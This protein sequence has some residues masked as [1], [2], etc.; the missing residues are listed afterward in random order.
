VLPNSP[1]F[2]FDIDQALRNQRIAAHAKPTL[3]VSAGLSA[4][5]TAIALEKFTPPLAPRGLGA[6]RWK[7]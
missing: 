5:N 3:D 1:E 7:N 6:E 2:R 4:G